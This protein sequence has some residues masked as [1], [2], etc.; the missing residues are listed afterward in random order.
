MFGCKEPIEAF[1]LLF[2]SSEK[3]NPM[4]YRLSC[5]CVESAAMFIVFVVLYC[6]LCG[7]ESAG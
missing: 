1:S 3:C 5:Q 2:L 4:H 6:I 7:D